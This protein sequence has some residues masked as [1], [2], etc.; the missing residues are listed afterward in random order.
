M[1]RPKIEVLYDPE[2]PEGGRIILDRATPFE[3]RIEVRNVGNVDAMIYSVHVIEA[4]PQDFSIYEV[5]EVRG[6]GFPLELRAGASI[7]IHYIIDVPSKPWSRSIGFEVETS[8]G[9][10]VRKFTLSWQ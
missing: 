3:G 5:K 1:K 4:L 6:R 8:A 7:I 9:R 10:F 2:R